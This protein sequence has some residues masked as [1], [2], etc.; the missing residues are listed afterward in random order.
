MADKALSFEDILAQA[1]GPSASSQPLSPAITSLISE[2]QVMTP[3][4]RPGSMTPA[5]E[6]L[7][8][9][10]TPYQEPGLLSYTAQQFGR[11]LAETPRAYANLI[12]A[13][14]SLGQAAISPSTYSGLGSYIAEQ[15]LQAAETGLDILGDIATRTAGGVAG[16]AVSVP[17]AARTLALTRSPA[18]AATTLMAGPAMGQ[19]AGGVA[20]DVAKGAATDVANYLRDVAGKAPVEMPAD[21]P[22]TLREAIGRVAYETP[23]NILGEGFE[24]G[25]GKT[26]K[27][28]PKVADKLPGSVSSTINTIVNKKTQDEIIQD[29][30]K[31]L[32]EVGVDK[33]RLATALQ[34]AEYSVGPFARNMTTAEVLEDPNLYRIQQFTQESVGGL[35]PATVARKREADTINQQLD[36]IAGIDTEDAIKVRK[37]LQTK[38]ATIIDDEKTRFTQGYES[39]LASGPTHSLYDVAAKLKQIEPDLFSTAKRKPPLKSEAQGGLS[40]DAKTALSFLDPNRRFATTSVT[41]KELHSVS[42]TLKEQARL[43]S[44]QIAETYGKLAKAID[45]VLYESPIGNDLKKLNSE[46]GSFVDTYAEG[47]VKSLEDP[48]VIT[49]ENVIEKITA[50][51]TAWKDSLA[52][53]KNDPEAIQKIIAVSNQ[54]FKELKT[55]ADKR[56]WIKKQRTNFAE[57]PFNETLTKADETLKALDVMLKNKEGLEE[58]LPSVDQLDALDLSDLAKV[59]FSGELSDISSIAKAKGNISRQVVRDKLRQAGNAVGRFLSNKN[60]IVGG[61]SAIGASFAGPAAA[62]AVGSTAIA[63]LANDVRNNKKLNKLLADALQTPNKAMQVLDAADALKQGVVK[64]E[65]KDQALVTLRESLGAPQKKVRAIEEMS[66]ER[67]GAVAGARGA[68]LQGALQGQT[69]A[70]SAPT[71]QSTPT[72]T[73]TPTPTSRTFEDILKQASD[74][75]IPPAEAAERTPTSKGVAAAQAKLRARGPQPQGNVKKQ[76]VAGKPSLRPTLKAKTKEPPMPKIG[77]A[78]SETRAKALQAAFK[79]DKADQVGLLKRFAAN[80]PY[81]KLVKKANPLVRAVIRTESNADHA[82]ISPVGAIGLM[83]LMP[84]TAAHLGVNPYDPEENVAGGSKYL[85]QMMDKYKNTDL[86]LAAYN[87][88]PGNV[89]KAQS[90]L[91]KKGISPTFANMVKY[92]GRVG[93]PR[94]TID[95][96][97]RVKANYK[98]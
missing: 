5:L 72:P 7:R 91:R 50:N 69:V 67:L 43:A 20:W 49:P 56:A 89:D 25:I 41:S 29:A 57:T 9:Q 23:Q 71:A 75:V 95:Y 32:N 96:I 13:L 44:G 46:Y 14:P 22:K 47:A 45:D 80:K 88:G 74:L 48:R 85:M 58:L 82:K 4:Y 42:S 98:K 76:A 21:V 15:P 30:A 52:K 68:A 38:L 66:R 61:L 31:V 94:E 24:K 39:V 33:Q 35:T 1:Q 84:G 92:A 97:P 86:A 65:M 27:A 11:G 18:A 93:L 40:S 53:F 3:M 55:I 17:A 37:D 79:L 63:R 28:L 6:P 10:T 16:A 60:A 62:F 81:E 59:G 2:P 34:N 8:G 87:W 78:W 12:A 64:P 36:A 51:T 77:G 19:A 83:Q 70:P 90:T 73:A 54:E 26:I